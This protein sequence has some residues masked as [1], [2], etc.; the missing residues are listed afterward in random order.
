MSFV[1][2]FVELAFVDGTDT[3][4]TLDGGDER[5]TLEECTGE[6]FESASEL[7]FAAGELV[8]EADNADVFFTSTLLGLD[9]TS[10]AVETDDQTASDFGVESTTVASLFN[11]AKCISW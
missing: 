4:L 7:S 9:E 5:R 10:S 6:C 2:E 11:A 3:E 8:V 1:V